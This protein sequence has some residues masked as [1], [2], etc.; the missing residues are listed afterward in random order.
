VLGH[1]T[2][3]CSKGK[4][5]ARTVEKAGSANAKENFKGNVFTRL[6]P[7]VDDSLIDASPIIAPPVEVP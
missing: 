2:G 4:E 1:S 7:S 5:E 3:A 6:R